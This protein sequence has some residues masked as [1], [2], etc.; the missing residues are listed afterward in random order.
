VVGTE[1]PATGVTFYDVPAEY[2]V[3]ED[4]YTV[5]NDRTVLVEPRSR[6]IVQIIG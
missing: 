1:L 3:T 4:K 2:G 6:R 5:I